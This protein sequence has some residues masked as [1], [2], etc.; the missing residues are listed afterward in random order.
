M[1]TTKRN[2]GSAMVEFALVLPWFLLIL[3]GIINYS[4][5]LFD[6]AIITNAA[7][8][9]ARW[10][11]I[12]TTKTSTAICS[13]TAAGNTDPCGIANRYAST[14]LINFGG[15][16]VSTSSTGDGTSGSEVIVTVTY[17]YT[18][19]GYSLT[20]FDNQLSASAVMYHE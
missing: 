8:E 4:I 7:R 11:A 19:L 17:Q 15:A 1:S 5:L 2:D 3:F 14:G 6:Q 18:G 10:G 9:G 20:T 12:H 13:S 16:T